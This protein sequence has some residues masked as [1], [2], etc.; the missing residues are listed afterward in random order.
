MSSPIAQAFCLRDGRRNFVINVRASEE[1]RSFYFGQMR[2]NDE[3]VTGA[4]QSFAMGIPPKLYML[5]QY[6]AG[7][8]HTLFNL[9]Y[10][11]QEEPQ[12]VPLPYTVKCELVECEFRKKTD[13]AYLYSQMMNA[14]GLDAVRNEVKGFIQSNATSNVEVLLKQHFGDDNVARVLHNLALGGNAIAL[15]KWLCGIGLPS[16]ELSTL[17]LPKNL[18]TVHEMTQALVSMGRLFQKRQVN[19]LFMLDELEGCSNVT[20]PDAQESIHDGFRKL[21]SDDNDSIGFIVS[22]MCRSEEEAPNFIMRSDILSRIGRGNV[23]WLNYLQEETDVEHFLRDLLNRLVDPAKKAQAESDGTIA[24]GLSWYPF[25][26]AAKASFVD[27]P[28]RAPTASTPR[29]IIKAVNE[30]AARAQQRGS[31]TIDTQDLEPANQIFVETA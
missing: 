5:G 6:G 18:D 1:D 30:C 16:S 23:K 19:F 25:T 24:S 10:R 13:F 7:K 17:Q 12:T 14:I 2:L 26:D 21:A 3:L 31:R 9:K 28:V 27:L 11:L 20:D 4:R 15:W 29:N 8:T 22:L